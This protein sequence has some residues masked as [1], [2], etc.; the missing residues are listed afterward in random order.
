MAL[1]SPSRLPG[2]LSV[3]GRLSCHC[4]HCGVMTTGSVKHLAAVYLSHNFSCY[5]PAI[6]GTMPCCSSCGLPIQGHQLPMGPRCAILSDESLHTSSLEPECTVCAQP[7]SSHPKGKHISK[8]CKFRC[9]QALEDIAPDKLD[10]AEDSHIQ[11]RL[12]CI[13]QENH[14]IKAQLNQLMELVCQLLPQQ[15]PAAWATQ[16]AAD[17]SNPSSGLSLMKGQFS[18][19]PEATLSL[20]PPSW[21]QPKEAT[22]GEPSSDHQAAHPGSARQAE[23]PAHHAS[24]PVVSASVAPPQERLLPLPS[25]HT[26]SLW[27][28]PLSPG[29]PHAVSSASPQHLTFTASQP[30]AQ[31][32]PTIWGKVQCSEY[33]DLS[34]LLAYSFQYKYSGTLWSQVLEIVDGKL[35]LAPK[36]KARHLSTLQL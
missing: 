5:C 35:S 21:P 27:A 17:I 34:E 31:V 16:Q 2:P 10:S 4:P 26:E 7:W 13:T 9:Q 30:P 15:S 25:L 36:C 3:A 1:P 19:T 23:A 28:A 8:E 6:T 18:G 22:L 11:A 29:T 12:M 24:L 32:P 20:S 33:I 14:A